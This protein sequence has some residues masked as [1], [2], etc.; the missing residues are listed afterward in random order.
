M[1]ALTHPAGLLAGAEGNNQLLPDGDVFAGWG[2]RARVSELTRGR[3][4]EVRP[5][6]AGRLRHLP[7][8]PFDWTGTPADEPAL[9]VQ[10]QGD[11][12]HAYASWNGATDVARWELVA[13]GATVASG[14]STGFE[15]TLTARSDAAGFAVRALAA[16][17]SVLGTSAAVQARR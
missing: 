4:A 5:R 7:R 8:V 14:P 9:A 12:L 2:L 17:G 16:D 15:T 10:R 1:Q 13:N 3:R 6:A 11:E